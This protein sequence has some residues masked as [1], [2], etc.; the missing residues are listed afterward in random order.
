MVFSSL[1]HE[2][3]IVRAAAIG[4][5]GTYAWRPDVQSHLDIVWL[6]ADSD[7][8]VRRAAYRHLAEWGDAADVRTVVNAATAKSDDWALL[9]VAEEL[10]DQL[11]ATDRDPPAAASVS[12][13][14]R[15]RANATRMIRAVLVDGLSLVG[16][17]ILRFYLS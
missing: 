16:W 9:I 1:S 2:A 12:R 13:L 11:R 8:R 6:V 14:G 4:A 3:P 17:L 5:F 10:T 15:R 7:P